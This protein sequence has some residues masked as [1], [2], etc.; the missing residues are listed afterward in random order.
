MMDMRTVKLQKRKHDVL[1][2]IPKDMV[3]ELP[4]GTK[5]MEIKQDR[6]GLITYRPVIENEI[7]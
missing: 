1:V 7:N 2:T 6:H 4:P 3:E 5:G